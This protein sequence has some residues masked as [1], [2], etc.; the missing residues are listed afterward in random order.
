MKSHL[1]EQRMP[2][3]NV[4]QRFEA[5]EAVMTST[6]SNK[7]Y[8]SEESTQTEETT[9]TNFS[10]YEAT[11]PYEDISSS[12]NESVMERISRLFSTVS[13]WYFVAFESDFWGN[14]CEF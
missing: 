7:P 5:T 6:T 2:P 1:D 4:D 13:W 9:M 11:T 12:E 3:N 14:I 10:D 8:F